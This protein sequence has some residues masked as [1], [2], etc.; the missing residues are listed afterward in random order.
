MSIILWN[1]ISTSLESLKTCIYLC[2]SFHNEPRCRP[3]ARRPSVWASIPGYRAAC[4]LLYS[5]LS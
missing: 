2:K 3:K 1:T 5:L 4:H